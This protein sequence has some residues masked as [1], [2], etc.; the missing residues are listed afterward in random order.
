MSV[1]MKDEKRVKKFQL[2]YKSDVP[3]ATADATHSGGKSD[4]FC[5]FYSRARAYNLTL[6]IMNFVSNITN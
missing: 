5:K 1:K 6:V 4:F 2:L 3:K